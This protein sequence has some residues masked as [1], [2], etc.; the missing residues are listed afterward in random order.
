MITND[1]I[2]D[3]YSKGWSLIFGR[4]GYGIFILF[5]VLILSIIWGKSTEIEEFKVTPVI[6]ELGELKQGDEI[7]YEGTSYEVGTFDVWYQGER[8]YLVLKKKYCRNQI[9]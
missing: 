5:L 4:R 9:T 6:Y 8:I 2:L 1:R 7:Q 3:Y